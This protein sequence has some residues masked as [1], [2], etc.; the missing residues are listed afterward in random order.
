MDTTLSILTKNETQNSNENILQ[1][2]VENE[3]D[4][5]IKINN[6]NDIDLNHNN[7]NVK[8]TISSKT[9]LFDKYKDKH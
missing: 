8:S 6:I 7:K 3:K 2:F 5:E 1:S 9:S 4:I